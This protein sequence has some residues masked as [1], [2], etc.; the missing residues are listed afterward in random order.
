MRP[1]RR[2]FVL[3]AI[4]VAAA[5]A[6]CAATASAGTAPVP[7]SALIHHGKL[8]FCSDLSSPPIDFVGNGDRAAGSDIDLGNA[9]AARL[10]LQP[11]WVNTV[12]A[13][14]I[15]ALQAHHCDAIMSELF[16]RAS[17]RGAVD[18]VDYAVSHR[19][20]LVRPGN[21]KHVTG[22]STLCGLK[23]AVET[24]TG[25]S[26][27]LPTFS[28]ACVHRGKQA[29]S[30]MLF[31]RDSDAFQALVVGHADAY[32]TTYETGAYLIKKTGR[33]AFGG[34]PW[35]SQPYGIA[36]NKDDKALHRALGRAFAAVRADGTYQKILAKWGLSSDAL[37]K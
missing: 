24:G 29:I 8:V 22:P 13:G 9:I 31:Q 33:V 10:G 26:K 25:I 6:L 34:K 17:R 15:P 27:L 14:I 32:G 12:F 23:V 20:F 5:V 4:A 21:P 3:R 35:S 18:F 30:I 11:V 1:S 36:T 37:T 7:D 16:D 2:P 19:A 28:T